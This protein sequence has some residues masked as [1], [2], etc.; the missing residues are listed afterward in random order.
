M[1]IDKVAANRFIKHAIAQAVRSQ[2]QSSEPADEGPTPGPSKIQEQP[3][4]TGATNK[5]LARTEWEKQVQE[6][7]EEEE[8]DLEIFEETQDRA[9]VDGDVEMTGE[10]APES[11]SPLVR[12]GEADTQSEQQSGMSISC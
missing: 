5:I 9:N 4:P 8:E 11:P 7:A 1:A 12:T 10:K 3:V 2:G 6:A